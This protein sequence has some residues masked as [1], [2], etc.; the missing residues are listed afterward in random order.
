MIDNN[1]N[2]WLLYLAGLIVLF[3][4]GAVKLLNGE[5]IE[6]MVGLIGVLLGIAMKYV[7]SGSEQ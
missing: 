3:A 4:F 5:E 1:R 2:R 7:P 6:A